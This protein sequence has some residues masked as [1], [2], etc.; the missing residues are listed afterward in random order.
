MSIFQ[1]FS[2]LQWGILIKSP[3]VS[4]Q[5]EWTVQMSFHLAHIILRLGLRQLSPCIG[6]RFTAKPDKLQTKG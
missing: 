2:T 5:V 3:N 6:H 4:R 1:D